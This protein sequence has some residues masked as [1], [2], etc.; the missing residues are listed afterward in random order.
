MMQTYVKTHKSGAWVVMDKSFP[1]GLFVVKLY[2]SGGGLI[3]KV[4][5]DDYRMAMDYRRS[6][7]AIAR[8]ALG[9]A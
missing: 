6:F 7:N 9:P 1:S 4:R 8:N 5:C 2:S 3:D